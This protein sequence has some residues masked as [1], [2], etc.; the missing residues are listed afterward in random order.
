VVQ[1]RT[2][3]KPVSPEYYRKIGAPETIKEPGREKGQLG[4][5]SKREKP[6]RRS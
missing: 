5:G 2:S 4:K 6:R 3:Q 1:G